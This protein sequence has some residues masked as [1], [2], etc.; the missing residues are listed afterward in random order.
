MK[1]DETTTTAKNYYYLYTPYRTKVFNVESEKKK[2]KEG[3][4]TEIQSED[5]GRAFSLNRAY[6]KVFNEKR[7]KQQKE[8]KKV[9]AFVE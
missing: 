8:K 1:S 3:I 2:K 9:I 6:T 7:K 4:I 5:G